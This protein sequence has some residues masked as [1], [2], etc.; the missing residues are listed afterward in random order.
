MQYTKAN[1]DKP[2]IRHTYLAPGAEMYGGEVYDDDGYY[3]KY[4]RAGK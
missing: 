4:Y 1:P 2:Q 3:E